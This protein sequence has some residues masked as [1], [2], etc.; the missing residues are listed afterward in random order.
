MMLFHRHETNDAAL[1][2]LQ[3]TEIAEHGKSAFASGLMTDIV[4]KLTISQLCTVIRQQG[5]ESE[6]NAM[7]GM[8][9]SLVV[10]GEIPFSDFMQRVQNLFPQVFDQID[11]ALLAKLSSFIAD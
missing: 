10:A 6:A 11:S 3:V 1:P 5:I 4:F 9:E 2:S 7:L 8:L